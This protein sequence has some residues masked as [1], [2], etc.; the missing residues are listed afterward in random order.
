VLPRR[1]APV[2]I[3]NLGIPTC[4]PKW[5]FGGSP[6]FLQ[7]RRKV[8]RVI[9]TSGSPGEGR[10]VGQRFSVAL[11]WTPTV[12]FSNGRSPASDRRR[13]G[14]LAALRKNQHCLDYCNARSTSASGL[15]ADVAAPV[16]DVSSSPKSDILRGYGIHYPGSAVVQDNENHLPRAPRTAE[17]R[18]LYP[19]AKFPCLS[20]EFPCYALGISLFHFAG[21]FALAY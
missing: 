20:S 5:H 12:C 15:K 11:E 10:G 2:G 14:L 3:Y 7:D 8:W 16:C 9:G 21:N 19:G 13:A 18:R 17:L 4:L 6:I 1:Y